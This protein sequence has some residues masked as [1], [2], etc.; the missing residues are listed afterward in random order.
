MPRTSFLAQIVRS[1]KF[2]A[3]HFAVRMSPW[4]SRVISPRTAAAR[5]QRRN[6]TSSAGTPRRR[7]LGCNVVLE[8]TR[9]SAADGRALGLPRAP[10]R[11]FIPTNWSTTSAHHP[12]CARAGSRSPSARCDSKR[13]TRRSDPQSHVRGL[14]QRQQ[15][16]SFSHERPMSAAAAGQSCPRRTAASR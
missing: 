4:Q 6:A 1:N 5:V 3:C 10:G 14:F 7:R 2:S 9:R 16:A 12:T 15:R 13:R 8:P 11:N